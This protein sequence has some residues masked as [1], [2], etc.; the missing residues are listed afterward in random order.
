M[1][2]SA[3][4]ST[5]SRTSRRS[6]TSDGRRRLTGLVRLVHPF[7][8]LLNGVIAAAVAL[9][10]GGGWI[11]S[12]LLGLAMVALQFSI[13][14]LNDLLDAD[15]DVGR[16]PSKPI[17]GGSVSVR[18]ARIVWAGTAV[19]GLLLV[20][21]SGAVTLGV[22]ALGLSIGYAYDRFARGTAWSW[23]PFALGIPLVPVYG[24][25][26][27]GEP[28]PWTFAVLV[29]CAMLAGASLAISNAAADLERDQAAGSD[30]VALRLGLTRA[31]VASLTLVAVPVTFMLGAMVAT[32][33]QGPAVVGTVGALGVVGMGLGL[34]ATVGRRRAT[35]AQRQR[36]WEIQAAG[37]GLFATVW[38]V[39]VGSY[40]A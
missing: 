16:T 11:T 31:W 28:L 8:S 30:S 35:S 36:A 21:P 1:A 7:P 32:S 20:V 24:W 40:V 29:P 33:L 23:V 3:S 15:R 9:V 26:G 18:T 27:T 5:S 17:P 10:A 6:S 39:A 19:V 38:L 13:G 22:A 14:T 25:V 4:W 2:A 37:M 34:G 12:L